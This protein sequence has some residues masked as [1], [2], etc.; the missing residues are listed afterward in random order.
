MSEETCCSTTTEQQV[1]TEHEKHSDQPVSPEEVDFMDG[2]EHDGHLTVTL[3]NR[4]PCSMY[5]H[6]LHANINTRYQMSKKQRSLKPLLHSL[7]T[8]PRQSV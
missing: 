4:H 7:L 8:A 1:G 5:V 6:T 2:W 3:K